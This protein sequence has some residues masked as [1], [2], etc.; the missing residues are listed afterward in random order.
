MHEAS[1]SGGKLAITP[2]RKES[3]LGV[4]RPATCVKMFRDFELSPGTYRAR[5]SLILQKQQQPQAGEEDTLARAH[6]D[7]FAS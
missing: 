3:T 7:S 1:V 4:V 2:G 5:A 6:T